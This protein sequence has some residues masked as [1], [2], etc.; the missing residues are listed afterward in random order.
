MN[1]LEHQ[2][3]NEILEG[4]SER[5]EYF[6]RTYGPRVFSLIGGII[7][8]REDAEELAQDVMLKAFGSLSEFRMDSSF[9]T[10]IYRIAYNMAIARARKQKRRFVEIDD[11][12]GP[13]NAEVEML[14]DEENHD[15][16]LID[17]MM[18]AL[19]AIPPEDRAMINM[20]YF[21]GLSLA[22]VAEVMSMTLGAVKVKIMRIRKKLYM[23]IN[24]EQK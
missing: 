12:D 8:C 10:W 16:R 3:I 6:V 1:Q 21:E 9:S 11:T 18:N 23:M 5:F 4:R 2:I 15:E 22:E 19:D 14:F 13:T 24:D 17:L 7:P 20:H